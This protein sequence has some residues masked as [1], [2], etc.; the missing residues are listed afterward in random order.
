MAPTLFTLCNALPPAGALRLRPG[1][2]GSAT[3]AGVE[4]QIVRLL[5]ARN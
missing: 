3:P 5:I 1:E 2:A 4:I